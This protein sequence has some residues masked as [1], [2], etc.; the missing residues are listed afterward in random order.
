MTYVCRCPRGIISFA[1]NGIFWREKLD[2]ESIDCEIQHMEFD[3]SNLNPSILAT[4]YVAF[5]LWLE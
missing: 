1:K 4:S 3:V 2:V 5:M